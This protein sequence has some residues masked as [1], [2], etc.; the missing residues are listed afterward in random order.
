MSFCV[1]SIR[2]FSKF[3]GDPY[4]EPLSWFMIMHFNLV[5]I[6]ILYIYHNMASYGS[7]ACWSSVL[8][9]ICIVILQSYMKAVF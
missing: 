1:H 4:Y 9:T 8:F 3:S 7:V 5:H 2:I 6:T